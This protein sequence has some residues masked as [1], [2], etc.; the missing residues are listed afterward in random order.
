MPSTQPKEY[1]DAL[2][3]LVAVVPW[4]LGVLAVVFVVRYAVVPLIRA[5]RC[6]DK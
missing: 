5:W 2:L 3:Q 4:V 6:K 1:V